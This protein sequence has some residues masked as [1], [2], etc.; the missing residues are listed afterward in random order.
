MSV[1][2]HN[3]TSLHNRA[4]HHTSSSPTP[5]MTDSPFKAPA[6]QVL[7]QAV[8]F[9]PMDFQCWT[10][11]LSQVSSTLCCRALKGCKPALTAAHML[12]CLFCKYVETGLSL[13]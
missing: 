1:E 2:L 11:L 4:G 9:D 12:S 7:W 10:A 8:T 3:C 6:L 13:P 5:V